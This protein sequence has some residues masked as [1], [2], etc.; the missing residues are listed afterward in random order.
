MHMLARDSNST[1]KVSGFPFAAPPAS[2]G[3]TVD[4]LVAFLR[5]AFGPQRLLWGSDWPV[6]ER[7]GGYHIV[8]SRMR[9]LFPELERDA[10]FGG[11]A[12]RIYGVHAE[13]TDPT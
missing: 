8:S 11:N 5:D 7:E 3:G 2:A 9:A 6:A 13:M 4:D 12:A 1:V 10:V